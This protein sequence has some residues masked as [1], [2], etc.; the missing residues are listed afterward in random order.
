MFQTNSQ[1]HCIGIISR[2]S[3]LD[4][5]RPDN[6]DIDIVAFFNISDHI[7]DFFIRR[8]VNLLVSLL[9]LINN[10]DLWIDTIIVP[11]YTHYSFYVYFVKFHSME[12]LLDL[13]LEV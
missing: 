9:T 11:I 12:F 13:Y 10:L 6:Q 5:I 8:R 4:S 7:L 2:Q 3:I 1:I